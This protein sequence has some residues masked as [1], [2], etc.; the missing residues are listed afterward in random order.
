MH[1]PLW[2]N[3]SS[4]FCP[5]Q[6]AD[7]GFWGSFG[8]DLQT[9]RTFQIS[10]RKWASLSWVTLA[11]WKFCYFCYGKLQNCCC[12]PT[13]E[14]P[15]KFVCFKRRRGILILTAELRL[16]GKSIVSLF[17]WRHTRGAV[18]DF[19]V[20]SCHYVAAIANLFCSSCHHVVAIFWAK[21]LR[22]LVVKDSR[23]R[24][25]ITLGVPEWP[26]IVGFMKKSSR[27]ANA[28][29]MWFS[30]LLNFFKWLLPQSPQKL[31]LCSLL[32]IWEKLSFV[33]N[34]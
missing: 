23:F 29:S 10:P 12:L 8:K 20:N 6:S 15:T 5:L 31:E 21:I 18:S 14:G 19:F 7:Y 33:P 22:R 26:W 32:V 16:T 2:E 1:L 13:T 3:G 9:A 30:V 34:C 24:I 28:P 11:V 4:W 25:R 17:S 27:R